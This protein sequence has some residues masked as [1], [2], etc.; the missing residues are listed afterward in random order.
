MLGQGTSKKKSVLQDTPFN[1]KK[2]HY[3]LWDK[4]EETKLG[5]VDLPLTSTRERAARSRPRKS[6]ASFKGG[7]GRRSCVEKIRNSRRKDSKHLGDVL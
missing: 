5:A 7:G 6:E 1:R 4:G 3:V 2:A